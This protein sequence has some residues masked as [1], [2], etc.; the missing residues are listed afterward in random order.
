[1]V[2]RGERSDG[3]GIQKRKDK[4]TIVAL[5]KVLKK[6]HVLYTNPI[7]NIFNYLVLQ[8]Q[9]HFLCNTTKNMYIKILSFPYA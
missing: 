5:K 1:M 6:L 4:R 9:N 3:M 7:T 2:A 8:L